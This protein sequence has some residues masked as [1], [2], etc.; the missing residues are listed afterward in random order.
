MGIYPSFGSDAE[1]M[2]KMLSNYPEEFLK[3]FGMGD[4]ALILTLLGYF[5][6]ALLFVQI[7]IAMQSSIYGFGILSKEERELTADFLLA[8]PIS[9]SE[10]IVA[11]F[12]AVMTALLI[13]DI[14]LVL[15]S[16][17]SLSVFS[18]GNTYEINDFLLVISTVP[19]FQLFFVSVG[20]LI[21][22]SVKKIRSVMSYAMG[23]SL[24][25]YMIYSIKGIIDSD[26]MG[27]LT[28]YSHFD[29]M[30]IVANHQWDYKMIFFN[31]GVSIV[32]L[33]S[34]YILYTKR[35]IHSL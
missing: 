30:Y 13:T 27:Y 6:F 10:V 12:M 21:S 31:I 15:F 29:I 24:G 28:P 9:R 17:L 4:L 35:N 32:S 22:V 1:L 33:V 26:L 2:T 19:F 7:L 5:A 16:L 18:N 34:A 20:M 14:I 11:K 8:K 23:F 3:A 25:L